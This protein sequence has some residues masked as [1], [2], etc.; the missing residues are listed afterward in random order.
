MARERAL[1]AQR[2]PNII[3]IHPQN[4]PYRTQ[5]GRALKWGATPRV[6]PFAR[7]FRTGLEMLTNRERTVQFFP[8][9]YQQFYIS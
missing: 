2:I 9:L 1:H 5:S 4:A 3:P 6:D 8:I 7:V